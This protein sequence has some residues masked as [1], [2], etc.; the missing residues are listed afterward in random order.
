MCDFSREQYPWTSVSGME[1]SKNSPGKRN[2][3][4]YVNS[5]GLTPISSLT[6]VRMLN[7][8]IGKA[9]VHLELSENDMI[10]ALS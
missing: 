5:A 2:V 10:D 1:Q 7:K 9:S 4:P 3:V 8:T 6:V